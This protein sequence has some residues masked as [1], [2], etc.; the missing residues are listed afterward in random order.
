MTCPP[1]RCP[2]RPAEHALSA[3]AS[4]REGPALLRDGRR[5]DN[6]A[7]AEHVDDVHLLGYAVG[8][9]PV[10]ADGCLWAHLGDPAAATRERDA[11]ADAGRVWIQRRPAHVGRVQALQPWIHFERLH[12]LRRRCAYVPLAA[13][14]SRS[15]ALTHAAAF[16]LGVRRRMHMSNSRAERARRPVTHLA[17]PTCRCGAG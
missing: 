5:D 10:H 12:K 11:N 17:C 13:L 8:S 15:R 4:R 3:L 7:G 14:G 2:P 9:G 6:E 1:S 16:Y